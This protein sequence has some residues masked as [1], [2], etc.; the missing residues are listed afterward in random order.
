MPKTSPSKTTRH[1][2]RAATWQLLPRAF[3][4]RFTPLQLSRDALGARRELLHQLIF[5]GLS[6]WKGK[7]EKK[8]P[9]ENV[10]MEPSAV[11]P[12]TTAPLPQGHARW[13]MKQRQQ[14]CFP[15][16]MPWAGSSTGRALR[17]AP[18][19][20]C[21]GS[22]QDLLYEVPGRATG[23]VRACESVLQQ[24][25]AHVMWVLQPPQLSRGGRTERAQ[26]EL[27]S[28]APAAGTGNAPAREPGRVPR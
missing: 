11:P 16:P 3:P 14:L 23:M 13:R 28:P 2:H 1:R 17:A 8:K 19:P 26:S 4:P 6:K 20:A 24:F 21:P 25:P 18:R 22:W 7:G 9:P 5:L 10:G 15:R 27:S 12:S